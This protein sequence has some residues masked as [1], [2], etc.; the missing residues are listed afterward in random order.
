VDG[1]AFYPGIT[2]DLAAAKSSIHIDQYGFRPGK[3][4]DRILP[5][6]IDRVNHGVPV[7]IV[8]DCLGSGA[9]TTSRGLYERLAQAG[10]HLYHRKIF[11]IDG[12]V[13]WV[14]GAGIEDYFID[15]SFH[16]MFVR[17]EGP[18]VAQL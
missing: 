12:R 6:L 7:R 2:E 10:G 8:V 11:V 3:V 17:I 9:D 13:G 15:G 14:G 4:A 5:V 16:D 1:A 18:T